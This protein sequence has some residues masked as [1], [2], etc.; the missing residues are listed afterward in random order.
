MQVTEQLGAMIT[1]RPKRF[2]W[3]VI[4]M[5]L[6]IATGAYRL[7]LLTDYRYYFDDDNPDRIAFGE[8]ESR[9]G[10]TDDII[11]GL[12]PPGGNALTPDNILKVAAL[13][14]ALQNTPFAERI[15]SV[16]DI[17]VALPGADAEEGPQITSLRGLA[18]TGNTDADLWQ[19]AREEVAKLT[20][21]T[22]LAADHSIAAAHVRVALP[23]G[24]DF[25]DT[26]A[27]LRHTEQVRDDFETDHPDNR[28]LLAGVLPYYH[29]ILELA[30]RDIYALFPFCIAI[31]AFMLRTL[32]GSWRA[33]GACAVPVLCAV[34]TTIGMNGWLGYPVTVA[35]LIVPIIV[36]VIAL[37][38]A[39]HF[40][41][42][43]LQLRTEHESASASALQS[44]RENIEPVLLTGGTTVLGFLAMNS[45]IAPPYRY[46]GNITAIGVAFAV[47]YVVL[48]M[49]AMLT[50]IDPPYWRKKGPLRLGL[51]YLGERY[52]KPI[53]APLVLFLVPLVI[54]AIL[55]CI[56]M[57]TIDD[58]I[59]EWFSGDTRLRQDNL[60]VDERLTGM[61]QLYYQLPAA[62]PTGV[63]DP[64]YLAKVEAFEAWLRNQE[65]V[66]AVRMLPN[67]VRSLSRSFGDGSGEIPDDPAETEQ[68]LWLYEFSA[69]PG[70]RATG[71]LN[72]D[73]TASLVH[74]S[75]R[76]RPGHEFQDFDKQ[77]QAWLASNA[78]ELDAPGGNSG[79]MMFSRMALQN[80]P[81][82]I[83]GTLAVLVFAAILVA[84]V[85]RSVRLGIISIVPN[86]LPVG[87]AFGTWGLLSGHIGIALS[88]ISTAALG[89]IVDDC[90][91]FL[92]RYKEGRRGGAASPEEACK[93]AIRRVGGAITITT[94]V[95]CV[96]MGL[97]G[98]SQVQ[99]THELGL[100]LAIAIAYAWFCD[101]F[102]LP[103]LLTRFD[104]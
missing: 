94:M 11:L 77:A 89:I 16:A 60:V 38:Y 18:E 53:R 93:H 67:L 15:T 66:V 45:S 62:G 92:E 70:D 40:C 84:V 7:T 46:M 87:L 52:S 21:G 102:L 71:L 2:V 44:L 31:A 14:D 35:T 74:V 55:A 73:R 24:N 43:H 59:S 1:A 28:V 97:I 54:L 22:L 57:N 9:F 48:V 81:P 30:M 19:R 79:V 80:I 58:N 50:L 86:L 13:A 23:E 4:L 20:T 37:A 96:G 95:L 85:L 32:L 12:E 82:M 47:L 3:S 51:E 65:G 68:L 8:L 36:L 103:Q 76:N 104:K 90:I 75:L 64:D 6:L 99:P 63:H 83:I 98:F 29:A 78:A 26:R 100:W 69:Q 17:A 41:D 27:V 56:P 5:T 61:Q 34:V 39:V 42:T 33:A 101:L 91:H 72:E 25:W 10:G 49:P 88:V